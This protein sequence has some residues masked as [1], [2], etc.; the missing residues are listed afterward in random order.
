MVLPNGLSLFQF[1]SEGTG[2]MSASYALK[3]PL[4]YLLM[5]IKTYLGNMDMLLKSLGGSILCWGESSIVV[6]L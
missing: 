1:G 2:K 3:E 4:N 5:S 6:L